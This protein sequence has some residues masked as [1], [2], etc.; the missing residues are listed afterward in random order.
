MGSSITETTQNHT[1]ENWIFFV[2]ASFT[3][4]NSN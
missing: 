4:Y 2:L 1:E 3:L